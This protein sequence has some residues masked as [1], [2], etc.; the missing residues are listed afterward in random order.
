MS[1]SKKNINLSK[2]NTGR[3]PLDKNT[4]TLYLLSFALPF[5]IIMLAFALNNFAPFGDRDVIAASGETDYYNY[6]FELYDHVHYPQLFQYN[7]SFP[8]NGVNPITVADST[9]ND[10]YAANVAYHLSDP[11]NF[12]ILLFNR[13]AIPAILNILYAI[14][15]GLCSLFLCIYLNSR[16]AKLLKDKEE[17][18]KFRAEIINNY[19][20]KLKKRD[21]KSGKSNTFVI[22][23]SGDA[24][25]KLGK[26][27][28]HFDF[29]SLSLS[30][31][32]AFGQFFVASGMNPSR[33]LAIA[34]FPLVL[35]GIDKIFEGKKWTFFSVFYALL[36]ILNIHIALMVSVFLIFYI[37][38]R[39]YKTIKILTN[40]LIELAK[41]IITSFLLV[42]PLLYLINQSSAYKSDISLSFPV[43]NSSHNFFEIIRQLLTRTTPEKVQSL[44]YSIDLYFGIILIFVF[45]LFIFNGNIKLARRIKKTI[46]LLLLLS[47]T[48]ITTTRYLFNGFYY[49]SKTKLYY[50]F[51]ISFVLVTMANELFINIEHIRS[52]FVNLAF[53]LSALLIISPLLFVTS[54]DSASPVIISLEF[55]F[56]YYI[57]SLTYRSRSLHKSLFYILIAVM[58]I[59]E[60]SSNYMHSVNLLGNNYLTLGYTQNKQY[61]VYETKLH[62]LTTNP[63][64]RI[65]F[66]DSNESDQEAFSTILNGYDFVI[67]SPSSQPFSY[68]EKVDS[69]D[70]YDIYQNKYSLKEA[71]FE[72]GIESYSYDINV[73]F[74]SINNISNYHLQGSD[75]YDVSSSGNININYTNDSNSYSITY[76]C[77]QDGDYYGAYNKFAHLGNGKADTACTIEQHATKLTPASYRVASYNNDGINNL[78]ANQ[79]SLVSGITLSY[80]QITFDSPSDGYI[81]LNS[82]LY[83]AT[84]SS[85][86]NGSEILPVNNSVRLFPVKKGSNTIAIRKDTFPIGMFLLS[87]LGLL[88]LVTYHLDVIKKEII[89]RNKVSS[90][91]AKNRIYFICYFINLIIILIALI[92]TSTSPFGNHILVTNDGVAQVFPYD[93][94]TWKSIRDGSFFNLISTNQSG[95]TPANTDFISRLLDPFATL[96]YLFVS[97]QSIVSVITWIYVIVFCFSSTSFIFYLTHRNGI[98]MKKDDNRLIP[99]TMAY[100]LSAFAI[101]YIT[102]KGF[103]FIFFLP[104][105][106]YAME[107]VIYK[108]KYLVY[109]ILMAW[110]MRNA[111]YAFMLCE[112]LFL[113][114]FTMNF[115]SIKDFL[116]KGLR[117]ALSSFASAGL[118][119]IFL[120]PFY[121]MTKGSNYA[122]TD[123]AQAPSLLSFFS[124]YL[125]IFNLEKAATIPTD[126]TPDF[127]RA[128]IYCGL[129]IIILIPLYMLNKEITLSRRIRKI[130][131]ITLLF[132]AFN[133]QFLNF[134]LHGFHLQSQV[135]NRFA[136]FYVFLA[137]ICFYETIIN[138]KTFSKKELFISLNSSCLILIVLWLI[139]SKTFD[140]STILSLAA[141]AIYVGSISIITLKKKADTSLLQHIILY[142]L[143]TELIINSILTLPLKVGTNIEKQYTT[144]RTIEELE[145]RNPEIIEDF[146]NTELVNSTIYNIA[147][148]TDIN[149]ITSFNNTLSSKNFESVGKWCIKSSSNYIAYQIGNPLADLML[150]VK[151]NIVDSTNEESYSIY[152]QIDTIKDLSLHENPYKLSLGI[153]IDDNDEFRKW[154]ASTYRDY[155]NAFAYQNA[156]VNSQG[157]SNIYDSIEYAIYDSE[158]KIVDKS[159]SYIIQGD[160]Y[161]YTESN[162]DINQYSNV[163]LHIANDIEGDIY[164]AE[165]NTILYLGTADSLNHEFEFPLMNLSRYSKYLK[166]DLKIA[167]FNKNNM[168]ALYQKLS[169][170]ETSDDTLS[171]SSITSKIN[172]EKDEFIYI[173]IPYINGLKTYVDGKEIQSESSAGG[174]IMKVPAGK[175]SI[176]IKYQIPGIWA[177]VCG[178]LITAIILLLFC[179]INKRRHLK[180]NI[181]EDKP[182]E[183]I[184]EDIN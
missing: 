147:Q 18:E 70:D 100:S 29:I 38:L 178:T 102:Y 76:S 141:I 135:P 2:H 33:T 34:I 53:I 3:K 63:G 143:A 103:E 52:I 139:K 123:A 31:C 152:P 23:G 101:T 130:S 78:Y 41:A 1:N 59:F 87:I 26:A 12:I 156:F 22:G 176:M 162:N 85:S 28:Y 46:L 86:I 151:Y 49:D 90:F 116:S 161:S 39:D 93:I 32:Y 182:I 95:I 94:Q 104:L 107:R 108:K 159:S 175:H 42:S 19:Q 158:D 144:I 13:S 149:T 91:I 81:M 174:I 131:L 184:T 15:L 133:N 75:I 35:L 98:R 142:V 57:F 117:F 96:I 79:S 64:A 56:A 138:W 17:S 10:N 105:I 180:T 129:G 11:S 4:K 169:S 171:Q 122:S 134:V 120:I 97:K 181:N 127:W 124:S 163:K 27:L 145:K 157:I 21:M 148:S 67:C 66:Y 119:S 121:M 109:I 146:T 40:G 154:D 43:F 173:S 170:I 114:F 44:Y 115:K 137:I 106:I 183:Q 51:I 5:I 9:L 30:I 25:S 118:A 92:A 164:I 58:C 167:V 73:P 62:I 125:D 84:S 83:S 60:L 71:F 20:E 72:S 179:I 45:V 150:R 61:K 132:I 89:N 24:K 37:A 136:I 166:P 36:W 54:Y 165:G 6:Y 177:G 55:L 110:F 99:I 74:E 113:Y 14:K 8:T 50:G 68:L 69:F 172:I 140:Y 112:F 7:E 155:K 88:L 16:K 126:V 111:Y 65:L 128:S 82:N 48:F 77:Y 47:G 80:D 168:K 153:A 160:A